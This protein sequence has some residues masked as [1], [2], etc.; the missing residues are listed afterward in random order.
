MESN[1][2][3]LFSTN[4][5]VRPLNLLWSISQGLFMYLSW[6]VG[7]EA[8]DYMVKHETGRVS[9]NKSNGLFYR[10]HII[11]DDIQEEYLWNSLLINYLGFLIIWFVPKRKFIKDNKIIKSK[12]KFENI[13][14]LGDKNIVTLSAFICSW[15]GGGC[16]WS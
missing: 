1:N 4:R 16:Q 5:S 7:S 10:E 14:L 12:T 2:D 9:M 15:Q 6:S 3:G 8:T 11:L 13:P